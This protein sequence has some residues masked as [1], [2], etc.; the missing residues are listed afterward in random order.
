MAVHQ[1]YLYVKNFNLYFV[2]PRY[3]QRRRVTR[4]TPKPQVHSLDV[5]L[6]EHRPFFEPMTGSLG[7]TPSIHRSISLRHHLSVACGWPPG[8]GRLPD[9]PGVQYTVLLAVVQASQQ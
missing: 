3:T 6:R 8:R 1:L 9:P 4:H 5:T 7:T 2:A